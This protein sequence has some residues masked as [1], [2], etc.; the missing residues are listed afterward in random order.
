MV[1]AMTPRFPRAVLA[2]A[3]SLVG[4]AALVPLAFGVSFSS[5]ALAGLLLGP[6]ALYTALRRPLDF[7]LGLYI[8]LIPYDNLLGTGSFGTL[9]KL[10]GMVAGA[11]LLLWVA[12]QR[13]FS[14]AS[15][16]ALVL[17]ALLLWMLVSTFWALDQS[18]ALKIMSTYAGLM[19]LYI[20][21][22]MM[23]VSPQ[24]FRTLLFLTVAGAVSAAIYGIHAFFKDPTF[25]QESAVMQR[26]VVAVGDNYIDPNHFADALL[27]P[28]SIAMMWGLRAKRLVPKIAFIAV[29]AILVLAVLY[30]GSREGL[31]ATF[32]IACYFIW[33]SRYRL[34]VS[35][36][37]G[38]L[39]ATALSAHTSVWLRFASAAQT[40]GSGRT[41]IWAVAVEA[42][43]HRFIQGYGIGNFAEAFDM[44]YLGVHQPYPYGWESPAHNLLLHYM[45]ELG[46]VGIVL[47]GA[48]FVMQFLS[49]RVI[50]RSSDLYD[51]RIALEAALIATV[52]VSMTIDLFTYKYAWLTFSLIALLRNAYLYQ[53]KVPMRAT[54]SPIIPVRSPRRR[55]DS[56]PE[57]PI[58]RSS[59]LSRHAS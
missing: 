41:S 36:V 50:P 35:L 34:Q 25:A 13:C 29:V 31:T 55:S 46:I 52:I 19:T 7:P 45:V 53:A 2:V 4:A 39:V 37:L 14:L 51:D 48:F 27:C 20:V 42:A 57:S 28:I 8:L 33:R 12:R 10:L 40:G 43:K 38:T 21:L 49:L 16:P 9:T 5:I 3:A 26:L 32:F 47:I 17:C 58:L 30:S 18:A 44:F 23:P 24:Q 54:S 1:E 11:F 59:A 56:L 22:T 6:I 15:R